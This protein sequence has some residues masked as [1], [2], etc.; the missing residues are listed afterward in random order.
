MSIKKKWF[1]NKHVHCSADQI[2]SWDLQV[3]A[4]NL[5]ICPLGM[6]SQCFRVHWEKRR[7][8]AKIIQHSPQDLPLQQHEQADELQRVNELSS[9]QWS[10]AVAFVLA[11]VFSRKN[12]TSKY[13][14]KWICHF[15]SLV[16]ETS[17]IKHYSLKFVDSLLRIQRAHHLQSVIWTFVAE[18]VLLFLKKTYIYI[19]IYTIP[20][21]H[22]VTCFSLNAFG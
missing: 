5:S 21:H 18:C 13:S 7:S 20:T 3:N 9:A 8:P 6:L 10:L 17:N 11:D 15:Y 12:L 19:Y 4:C 14:S 1:T 22:I 2:F 16:F